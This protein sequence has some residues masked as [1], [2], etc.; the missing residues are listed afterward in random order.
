VLLKKQKQSTPN[1]TNNKKPRLQ[2]DSAG[3]SKHSEEAAEEE[4]EEEEE[5][6]CCE[7]CGT[8]DIGDDHMLLCDG[9][10]CGHG[11]HLRCLKPP[12]QRIPEGPWFCASCSAP[13][14][15]TVTDTNP[16]AAALPQGGVGEADAPPV[17]E[18]EAQRHEPEAG[19]Q[20]P[21]AEPVV[22]QPLMHSDFAAL[23]S[24]L[25]RQVSGVV[26]MLRFD[27]QT[28]PSLATASQVQHLDAE[29]R[30][31]VSAAVV[32]LKAELQ[33]RPQPATAAEL[34]GIVAAALS[35][36][37]AELRHAQSF[38][39][40]VSASCAVQQPQEPQVQVPQE[41][42]V[43][44]PQEPQV[45]QVQ[46][47]QEGATEAALAGM[48]Y[49]IDRMMALFLAETDARVAMQ[50]DINI[51]KERIAAITDRIRGADSGS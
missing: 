17:A 46:V 38:I 8:P 2:G 37:M 1:K 40:N 49:D 23:K 12:L 27:M 18:A 9:H 43:Q 13:A 41:P 44:V 14:G 30:R 20:E 34:Q 50:R 6:E 31:V 42:Q 22:Q 45:T 36:C 24:E 51:L 25:Q 47:P 29:L 28:R 3:P 11:F 16:T 5:D 21:A 32:D 33:G 19:E 7:V 48:R 4:E 10:N 35:V 15:T 39:M 26:A